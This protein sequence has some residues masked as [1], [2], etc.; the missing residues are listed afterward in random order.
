[1]LGDLYMSLARQWF[2]FHKNFRHPIPNILVVFTSWLP[3]L[4]WDR[5]TNFANQL[6]ARFIHA[7]HR[8]GRIV[9]QVVYLQNILYR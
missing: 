8:K 3:R 7:H 1:M 4:A 9:R 6:F 2:H 5:I